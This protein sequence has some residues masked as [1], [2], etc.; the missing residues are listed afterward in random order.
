MY[1]DFSEPESDIKRLYFV[2]VWWS[3]IHF[4]Q[5]ELIPYC[6][7]VEGSKLAMSYKIINMPLQL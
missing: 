7:T 2:P 6:G 4:C 5:L 1:Q 3:A